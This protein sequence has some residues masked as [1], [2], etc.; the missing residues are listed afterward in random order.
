[1]FLFQ[2]I[3]SKILKID[4]SLELRYFSVMPLKVENLSYRPFGSPTPLF[5]SL[6]FELKKGSLNAVLGA[7]GAGKSTLLSLLVGLKNK[8]QGYIRF[9]QPNSVAYL[10]QDSPHSHLPLTLKEF[11]EVT[12]CAWESS[13]PALQKLKDSFA[14]DSALE[15]P[16][17]QL[18]LGQKRKA[19]LLRTFC[20]DKEIY[21]LDEPF[22]SLDHSAQYAL[23]EFLQSWKQEG[24][25]IL[26]VA[27]EHHLKLESFFDSIIQLK[28]CCEV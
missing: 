21:I 9:S 10:Q 14:L 25:T 6:T 20:Q 18:S 13:S 22:A 23:I 28:K 19:L 15:Y 27:H 16:F 12:G 17:H 24:K 5:E 1:M 7:N 8:H 3:K 26:T 11:F 4:I 2:K